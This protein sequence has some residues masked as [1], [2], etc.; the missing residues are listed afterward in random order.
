MHK[1]MNY[2]CDELTE[3]ERKADKGGKLTMAET[4]YADTLA[5]LKKN[6]LKADE[7]WNES[8]YSNMGESYAR[9]RRRANQYGSYD[10]E[11]H[12]YSR[13]GSEEMVHELRRLM[14]EAPDEGTRM[15]FQKFIQK[16]ER[17]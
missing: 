9:G 10:M 11:R 14:N 7:M 4:Q 8:E 6:L 1:L 16:I 13:D 3:L 12:D 5:H 15:E 2:I 17:M